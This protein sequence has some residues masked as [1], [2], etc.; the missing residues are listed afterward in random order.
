MSRNK[1]QLVQVGK[2]WVL[3]RWRPGIDQY[4]VLD[5]KGGHCYGATPEQA[6]TRAW[7][8]PLFASSKDEALEFA[9]TIKELEGVPASNIPVHNPQKGSNP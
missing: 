3:A 7:R 4:C 8:T 5:N 9:G 1:T 6:I 2:Q